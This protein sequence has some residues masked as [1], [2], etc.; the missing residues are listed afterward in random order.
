MTA[1]DPRTLLARAIAT[2]YEA[3]SKAMP[4]TKSRGNAAEAAVALAQVSGAWVAAGRL[5]LELEGPNGEPHPH[6][7]VEDGKEWRYLTVEEGETIN[8]LRNGTCTV[9][10]TRNRASSNDETQ[11]INRSEYSDS[12]ILAAAIRQCTDGVRIV[13]P[14]S[15]ISHFPST[16]IVPNHHGG[17]DYFLVYPRAVGN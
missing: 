3:E 9:S 16:N 5:A 2:A 17:K 7:P 10:P 6:A 11:V 13:V 15:N 8:G 1:N 4:L 12:D 14:V